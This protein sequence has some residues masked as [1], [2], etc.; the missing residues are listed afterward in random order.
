MA[1]NA[2]SP[3]KIVPKSPAE[4]KRWKDAVADADREK[5]ELIR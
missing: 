3:H 1:G 4:L 5:P 2:N